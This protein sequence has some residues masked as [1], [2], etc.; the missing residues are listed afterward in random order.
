MLSEE[1]L[2]ESESSSGYAPR[3]QMLEYLDLLAFIFQVGTMQSLSDKKSEGFSIEFS[4]G[5]C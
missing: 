3:N 4:L 2:E 1:S 5:S